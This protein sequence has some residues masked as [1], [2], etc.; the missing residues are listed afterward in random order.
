LAQ[1]W[2]VP[3]LGT[4]CYAP[5]VKEGEKDRF[6]VWDYFTYWLF[7]LV[8]GC[9]ETYTNSAWSRP[10]LLICRLLWLRYFLTGNVG[11]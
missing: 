4:C 2:K 9:W 7:L 1:N 3:V 8:S 5:L 6:F 10:P 11:S